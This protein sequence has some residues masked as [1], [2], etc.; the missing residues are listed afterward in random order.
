MLSIKENSGCKNN[1]SKNISSL[2]TF[3]LLSI[4]KGWNASIQ[5]IISHLHPSDVRLYHWSPCKFS[6]SRIKDFTGTAVMYYRKLLYNWKSSQ[7]Q[8]DLEGERWVCGW[9]ENF[10]PCRMCQAS[11][12]QSCIRPMEEDY[13]FCHTPQPE[14]NF[15]LSLLLAMNSFT[16]K[17]HHTCKN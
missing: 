3:F 14:N 15:I 13:Q 10:K 4:E 16:M 9:K 1:S 12:F 6:R 2:S 5:D 11:G 7:Q 8:S 17:S